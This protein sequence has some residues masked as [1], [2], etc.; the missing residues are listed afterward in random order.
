MQL[1]FTVQQDGKLPPGIRQTLANV[2]PSY[3]GK[4]VRMDI[5]E[6]KEKRSLDQNSYYHA[7]IVPHVRKVRFEMGDPLSLDQVHEDLLQQFSPTVTA[8]RADGSTYTRPKRSKELSVEDMRQY[9]D[10]II[11]FIGAMGYPLSG[12]L[13]NESYT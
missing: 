1:S 5:A 11:G 10:A 2:I 4:R 8:K 13:D 7:A 6:A 9:L 3:A 12:R